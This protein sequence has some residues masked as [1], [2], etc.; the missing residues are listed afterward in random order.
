MAKN[1]VKKIT[2]TVSKTSKKVNL[3]Y[4]LAAVIFIGLI[5][6][7][8]VIV[9]RNKEGFKKFVAFD[10][11]WVSKGEKGADGAKGEDAKFKKSFID[12]NGN[13]VTEVLNNDQISTEFKNMLM[14]DMVEDGIIVKEEGTDTNGDKIIKFFSPGIINTEFNI[15][16]KEKQIN[17]IDQGNWLIGRNRIFPDKYF[18]I[19]YNKKSNKSYVKITYTITLTGHNCQGVQFRIYSAEKINGENITNERQISETHS[20]AGT[21]GE[22]IQRQAPKSITFTGIDTRNDTNFYFVKIRNW[23]GPGDWKNNYGSIYINKVGIG[24][25]SVDLNSSFSI[26]EIVLPKDTDTTLSTFIEE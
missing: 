11:M 5:I 7:L 8:L 15:S 9:M 23:T 1:V 4:L 6:A 3:T 25:Y 10:S 14:D 20:M 26:E 21:W 16:N 18:P 19:D 12:E 22:Y 17:P 24:N 13:F 2:N